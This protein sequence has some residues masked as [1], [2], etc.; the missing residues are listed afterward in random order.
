MKIYNID[1]R[2]CDLKARD[3]LHNPPVGDR[4]VGVLCEVSFDH[5]LGLCQVFFF[6]CQSSKKK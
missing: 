6:G 5:L 3:I 2:K 4:R 1:K